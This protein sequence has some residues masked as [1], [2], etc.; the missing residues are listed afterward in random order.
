MIISYEDEKIGF[1]LYK[2]I[3][4]QKE[5]PLFTKIGNPCQKMCETINLLQD[6][7]KTWLFFGFAQD[8]VRSYDLKTK[9][10]LHHINYPTHGV[11]TSI[12]FITKTLPTHEETYM[13]YSQDNNEKISLN[14]VN[15]KDWSMH[16]V[17]GFERVNDLC[18]WDTN[19]ENPQI[20][21]ADFNGLHVITLDNFTVS[22]IVG[23]SKDW[24][25]VSL[26]KAMVRNGIEG[27]V[28]F[29]MFERKKHVYENRIVLYTKLQ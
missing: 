28:T 27:V 20:L 26:C 2:L 29:Q 17:E 22:S 4:K 18:V 16:T 19:C 6:E 10:W 23:L 21:V 5:Q 3:E 24:I 7:R 11:V 14:F 9:A 15:M 1:H 8:A 12:E 25:N 13:V